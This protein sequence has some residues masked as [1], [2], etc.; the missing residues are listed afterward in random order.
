[1]LQEL[2]AAPIKKNSYLGLF[3]VEVGGCELPQIS[4]QA[5]A[6][7]RISCQR[8]ENLQAT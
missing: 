6:A 4:S 3:K 8:S 1:M 2:H 5:N 7:E